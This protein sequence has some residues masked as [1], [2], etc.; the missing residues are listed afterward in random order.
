[1]PKRFT[2]PRTIL[3]EYA[4]HRQDRAKLSLRGG[5][6][7]DHT[8]FVRGRLRVNHVDHCGVTPE[9]TVVRFGS[10]SIDAV[11]VCVVV[12]HLFRE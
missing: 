9:M 10:N 12:L 4:Y 7:R 8:A 5:H 11:D 2:A 1:M 6:D 3:V